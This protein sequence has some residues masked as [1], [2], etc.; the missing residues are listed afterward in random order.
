MLI[1]EDTIAKSHEHLQQQ[2]EEK[3]KEDEWKRKLLSEKPNEEKPLDLDS[4]QVSRELFPYL[5]IP[6]IKYVYLSEQEKQASKMIPIH[7]ANGEKY[8]EM[9]DTDVQKFVP[10]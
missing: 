1:D 9:M 5:Y 4:S 6:R 8:I 7:K 10:Y 3:Y 2:W